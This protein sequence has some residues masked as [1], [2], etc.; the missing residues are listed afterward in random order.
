MSE[1]PTHDVVPEIDSNISQSR[2]VFS[3][4][5]PRRWILKGTA[6]LAGLSSC[7]G[8]TFATACA[9]EPFDR[10][11]PGKLRL[12]MA[13]YSIRDLLKQKNSDWDLFRFVDYCHELGLDGAE[14]T[15]YYFPE[16]VDDAYLTRLRLH[17][18]RR[19][20]SISGGAIANDFCQSD[21]SKRAA[22][23]EHTK[24]WIDRYAIL[25]A[26]VIRIFAGGQPKGEEWSTTLKRCTDS[27]DEVT[28]YATKRG[29][30]LGLENHGGVTSTASQ[31]LEIVR[32]VKGDGFG[33]NLDS[34]NFRSTN[35]PYSELEQIAPYA[36]NA[37][38]KVEMFPGGK[39]EWTDI[40][41]VLRI[42]ANSGYSGFVAL[43]YEASDPPLEA[44]PQWIAK[45]QASLKE[46]QG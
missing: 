3:D 26:P 2:I 36:V 22:D 35:D 38:L 32:N 6:A 46:L 31:L 40:P 23:I 34:G 19:G 44:I 39:K 10:P 37:Q 27:I 1:T 5:V 41:R 12:S 43:E 11:K 45:L 13:A 4:S 17:C 24:R 9:I 15:S 16:N 28:Q 30:Y 14:L 21:S 8:L 25:G 18:H 42:L 20:I 29:I 7:R 33:V